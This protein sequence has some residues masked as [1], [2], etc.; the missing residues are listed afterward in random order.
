MKI[1]K[2]LSC[3]GQGYLEI[4]NGIENRYTVPKRQKTVGGPTGFQK[5]Q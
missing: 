4:S 1:G 2:L 3:G 5:T